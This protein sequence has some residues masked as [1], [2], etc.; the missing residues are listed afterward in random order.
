MLIFSMLILHSILI[1]HSCFYIYNLPE[2]QSYYKIYDKLIS[3]DKMDI[4]ES[5]DIYFKLVE[6]PRSQ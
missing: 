1:L 6:D 5:F 3:G 2:I 4:R